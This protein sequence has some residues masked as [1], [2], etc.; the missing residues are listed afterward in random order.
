MEYCADMSLLL[1]SGMRHEIS[2]VALFVKNTERLFKYV[3]C[4][5]WFPFQQVA[6]GKS[7]PKQNFLN[8]LLHEKLFVIYL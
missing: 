4:V 1:T 5:Q 7:C 8:I 6:V 2:L 3:G